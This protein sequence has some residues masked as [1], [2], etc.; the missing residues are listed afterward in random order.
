[1]SCLEQSD[2][3]ASTP[4]ILNAN[5]YLQHDAAHAHAA[6]SRKSIGENTR[7]STKWPRVGLIHKVLAF[8]KLALKEVLTREVRNISYA[9]IHV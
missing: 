4:F 8:R 6:F 7:S 3:G 1:M 5:R 9:Y 2:A